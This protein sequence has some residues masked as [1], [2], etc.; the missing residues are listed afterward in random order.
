MASRPRAT[1]LLTRSN[2]LPRK[3]AVG[4][5]TGLPEGVTPNTRVAALSLPEAGSR[6]PPLARLRH[7]WGGSALCQLAALG[8]YRMPPAAPT[9]AGASGL[10][11]CFSPNGRGRQGVD[12]R[13]TVQRAEAGGRSGVIHGPQLQRFPAGYRVIG[14]RIPVASVAWP[15]PPWLPP[16]PFREEAYGRSSP[17]A[18]EMSPTRK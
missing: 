6:S 17:P 9:R 12:V 16:A 8:R 2:P 5:R 4:I 10:L 15:P 11:L 7:G 1:D 18:P 3:H 13:T 14:V